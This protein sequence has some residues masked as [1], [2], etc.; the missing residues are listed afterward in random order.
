MILETEGFNIKKGVADIPTAFVA[1]YGSG[2]P[3]IGV[4]AEFDDGTVCAGGADGSCFW[5]RRWRAAADRCPRW[6]RRR[7]K[8][9]DSNMHDPGPLHD[10]ALVPSRAKPKSSPPTEGA[11]SIQ[12]TGRTRVRGRSRQG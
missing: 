11:E 1:E 9:R 3:I 5:R 2:H 4:L 8:L 6:L 10:L 7:L 12:K